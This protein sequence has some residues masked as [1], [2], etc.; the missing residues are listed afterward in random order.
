MSSDHSTS[1]EPIT[2]RA[3]ISSR[4]FSLSIS[5]RQHQSIMSKASLKGKGLRSTIIPFKFE[6]HHVLLSLK[7]KFAVKVFP[8]A[9]PKCSVTPRTQLSPISTVP[10]ACASIRCSVR[11]CFVPSYHYVPQRK[12]NSI[13]SFSL[14]K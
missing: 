6:Q 4:H 1:S 2:L 14:E 8:A 7:T 12:A 9:W 10:P 3:S 13:A 5:W 11:K